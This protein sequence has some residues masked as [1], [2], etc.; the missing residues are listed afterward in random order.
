MYKLC[1]EWC[2]MIFQNL[3]F[4]INS[5][6]KKDCTHYDFFINNKYQKRYTFYILRC[7][8][9]ISCPLISKVTICKWKCFTFMKFHKEGS[10]PFANKHEKMFSII[11]MWVHGKS[12]KFLS[13]YFPF[14]LNVISELFLKFWI[15]LNSSILTFKIYSVFL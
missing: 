5:F 1:L 11:K 9:P 3:Q 8:A 2:F 12:F 7:L 14:L 10:L 13:C 15:N 6:S 4:Y